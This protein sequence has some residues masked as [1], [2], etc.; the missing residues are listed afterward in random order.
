VAIVAA[1]SWNRDEG[2]PAPLLRPRVRGPIGYPALPVVATWKSHRA[3]PLYAIASTA[4]AGASARGDVAR[5]GSTASLDLPLET[6]S[7][8]LA[9]LRASYRRFAAA[10]FDAVPSTIGEGDW[11]IALRTLPVRIAA[12]VR[13]D[14]A[15][16]SCESRRASLGADASG[17][18]SR[19]AAV[20]DLARANAI[21]GEQWRRVL[22]EH[23]LAGTALDV[24]P[25]VAPSAPPR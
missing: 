23:G 24:R 12:T 15:A 17:I 7:S 5:S 4:A 3:G 6:I 13:D 14:G 2:G 21:P 22:A 20:A 25:P 8:D 1:S 18:E 19:F 9:A 16:V 10:C 11:L